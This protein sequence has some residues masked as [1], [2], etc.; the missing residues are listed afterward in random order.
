MQDSDKD[1]DGEEEET[2]SAKMREENE[3]A[4]KRVKDKS[5]LF[6]QPFS[7]SWSPDGKKLAV[8]PKLAV[9]RA[10]RTYDREPCV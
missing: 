4:V 10:L 8:K 7:V 3:S 1:D 9:E 2:E 5:A 6:N